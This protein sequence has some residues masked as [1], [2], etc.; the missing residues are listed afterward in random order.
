MNAGF[1]T[2]DRCGVW[3][4]ASADAVMGECR[5]H[6]PIIADDEWRAVWPFTNNND[7]C[8][9]AVPQRS[10]GDLYAEI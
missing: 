5:R 3:E 2:C 10:G 6:A 4:T 9:D 1:V 8:C 7:G